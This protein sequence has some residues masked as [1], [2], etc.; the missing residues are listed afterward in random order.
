MKKFQ[1]RMQGILDLKEK[2][3]EQEKTNYAAAQEKLN[4]EN[5]KLA[6]LSKRRDLYENR[7]RECVGKQ[8]NVIEIRQNEDAVE[9]LKLFIRQQKIMV[10]KAEQNVQAALYRLDQAMIERK[11]QE[12]LREQAHAVYV[13]ES[14]REERKEVDELVSFQYCNAA[15]D[16]VNPL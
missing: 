14:E 5:V 3:E 7:L 2:L 10:R 9:S 13:E 15:E 16:I 1:Y 8:L 11:T 6:S 12:K 4:A